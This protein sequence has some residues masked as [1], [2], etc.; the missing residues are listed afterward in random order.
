[1][2]VTKWAAPTAAIGL[3]AAVVVGC[4]S[5]KD[6]DKPASSAPAATNAA[7]TGSPAKTEENK[8]FGS[9]VFI[10]APTFEKPG[11]KKVSDYIKDKTGAGIELKFAENA[12]QTFNLMIA[13]GE[14]VDSVGLTA[15]DFNSARSKGLLMPLDDLLAKYGTNLKK[16]IRPD[17]WDWTKG[18]DGKIYAIPNE[19]FMFP[20]VP[21]IRAD[22]L[23]AVKLPVP[24]TIDDFEKAM[25][26][27]KQ[28]NPSNAAKKGE[29]YPIFIEATRAD[30]AL[31]GGFLKNGV[32]WWKSADG[33][34]L[35]P[36]MDPDYKTYLQTLQNWYKEKLVHPET[37]AITADGGATKLKEFIGQ[38]LVGATI[39]SYG[40][41]N[42]QY[43]NLIKLAP[44]YAYEPTA[45]SQKYANGVAAIRQPGGF[46]VISAKAK[47][48]EAAIRVYD[49]I[50]TSIENTTISRRGL[51]GIMY[52]YTD[53]AKNK[54]KVIDKVDPAQ[55][56]AVGAFEFLDIDN[57]VEETEG[58]YW[59]YYY[60]N[61]RKMRKLTNYTPL[62]QALNLNE[63]ILPSVQKNKATLDAAKLETFIRIATGELPVSAWD[64][65]LTKWRKMGMDD[66]IKEKNEIY[67]K[68]GK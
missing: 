30:Q 39:G 13:S 9:A 63:L 52:D 1:M 25:R 46:K 61:L 21:Y 32:S 60:E 22:W 66:I 57:F 38:D 27:I 45:L 64:E 33:T 19:A 7:A 58:P 12:A 10:T 53:K 44:K 62:D 34:Y 31:L 41:D 51:P 14:K 24:Q 54:I 48:A 15:S 68:A 55:E 59:D 40:R 5:S 17:L 50:A 36:E 2:H 23:A 43:D 42:G 18:D 6:A 8:D 11:L 35:P 3:L 49:W 47:N 56:F 20:N 4:S 29:L 65:F 67:K 16:N 37:Y 26:A 28:L